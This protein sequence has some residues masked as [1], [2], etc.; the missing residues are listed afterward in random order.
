[1]IRHLQLLSVTFLI[2]REN[3][4]KYFKCIAIKKKLHYK[5]ERSLNVDL[6]ISFT[7]SNCT[8]GTILT[9]DPN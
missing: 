8:C 2:R 4:P 5:G 9:S 3:K 7:C 6:N 1:M